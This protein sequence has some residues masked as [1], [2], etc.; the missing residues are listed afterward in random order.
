MLD[1]L[2]FV[3]NCMLHRNSKPLELSWL[4]LFSKFGIR[5]QRVSQLVYNL[6]YIKYRLKEF[7]HVTWHVWRKRQQ[8]DR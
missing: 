8:R 2:L 5:E 6:W 1:G 7:F 3:N 4:D